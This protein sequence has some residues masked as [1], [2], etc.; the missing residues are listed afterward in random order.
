M[1]THA[2]NVVR[3]WYSCTHTRKCICKI[4]KSAFLHKC[5]ALVHTIGAYEFINS[6][7]WKFSQHNHNTPLTDGLYCTMRTLRMLL[8]GKSHTH[9]HGECASG[10]AYYSFCASFFGCCI[11][12]VA[13]CVARRGLPPT[14]L[15]VGCIEKRGAR[16]GTKMCTYTKYTYSCAFGF[17][18]Y[19]CL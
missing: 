16:V 17:C 7:L 1:Y 11:R 12:V 3:I 9:Q 10:L 14:Q 15:T 4:N 8:A 6:S 13:I 5:A 19:M 2:R 18:C